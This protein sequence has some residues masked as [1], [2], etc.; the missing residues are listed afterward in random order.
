MV[1]E[2]PSRRYSEESVW[3]QDPPPATRALTLADP[4][5]P[6]LPGFADQAPACRLGEEFGMAIG[7]QVESDV[8]MHDVLL[9]DFGSSDSVAAV[10]GMHIRADHP[11][12]HGI[13]YRLAPTL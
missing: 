3:L 7:D 5:A 4:N 10:A 8:R 6:S 9:D 13:D 11:S 12:R 2:W 1:Q